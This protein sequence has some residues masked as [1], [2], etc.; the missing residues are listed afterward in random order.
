MADS[1][2]Q[3]YLD[4]LLAKREKITGTR[5]VAFSDQRIDYDPVTL[6]SEIARVRLSLNRTRTSRVASFSK[7]TS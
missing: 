6:A 7:G 3:E 4:K 1:D 2:T 5:G